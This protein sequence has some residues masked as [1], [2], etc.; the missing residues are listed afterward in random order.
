VIP[1]K[2]K[3]EISSMQQYNL[4]ASNLWVKEKS[5]SYQV[6]IP[7]DFTEEVIAEYIHQ[8]CNIL[9][10]MDKKEEFVIKQPDPFNQNTTS[11]TIL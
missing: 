7:A 10:M 5:H 6:I 3:N 4:Y 11:K 9:D 8:V 2:R 1:A